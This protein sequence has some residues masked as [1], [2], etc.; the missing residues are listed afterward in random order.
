MICGCILRIKTINLFIYLLKCIKYLLNN[1]H[2]GRITEENPVPILKNLM[3][4]FRNRQIFKLLKLERDTYYKILK[5]QT[6]EMPNP[7]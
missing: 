5:K 3:C 6:T 2:C 7:N 1:R 4:S